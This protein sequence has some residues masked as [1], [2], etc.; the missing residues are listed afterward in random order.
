MPTI[1]QLPTATAPGPQDEIPLSQ[2]GITRAVTVADLLSGT[3]QAIE[4]ASPSVLGRASL[5]PGGPEALSLGLGLAVQNA[6][7]LANGNDHAAFVQETTFGAGDEAIINA[8]GIP[9][10]LPLPGL[11][12]LFSGGSNVSIDTNGVIASTTDPSVS[13]SLSTLTQS[14]STTQASLATLAS[15]IPTGGIAGLNGAGQVTAPIAGDVSLGKVLVSTGATSR[16]VAQRAGDTINVLDFGAVRGGPDCTAAFNAAIAALPSSGAELFIP[17][18]EYWFSSGVVVNGKAFAMKGAGRGQTRLH[19]QH[20]GI[21]FDISPGDIL[22]KVTLAGF[23]LYA[24]SSAGQTAAGI[25][26]TY[27]ATSSFGYVSASITEIEF[28]G[29]PNGANGLAPFP[30]TFLRGLVL[31]GCWSTEINSISW[32]GPPAAA[33]VTQSAV[34][35]L[36]QSFD[37]RMHGIQAYYGNALI[38]QTGYCEGIYL[39]APVVV[40]VD[41]LML[42]TDQTKWAGYAP[43]KTMLLGLWISH[44]EVNTNL[45]TVLL[46]NVTAGFLAGLDITRDGGPNTPQVLFN[47]TNVSNFHV[48]GCNFV[49][50]PTGGNSA[51]VAFSFSSTSDSSNNI[52]DGCHFED[53]ATVIQINGSNGTVGLT[54][55]GLNL[56]NVP[57][58]SAIIDHSD[59]TSG[60]YLSF[61]TPSQPGAPAGWGNSKDHVFSNPGGSILFRISNIQNAANFIRHQAATSSNPPTVCFDG[62][63]GTV[64]GVIQTKGGNLFINAAGGT[65]GSGNIVSLMNTQ[66]ATNWP[67]LQNATTGNLSL[68]STNTGGLGLQPKGALWLSPATGLFA[69]GLPTVK[70]ASGSNQIWNNNGV[71]SIA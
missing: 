13:G 37:T 54:T 3:Q 23:S 56:G 34:I 17:A 32:F 6:S 12:A 21:G 25:R 9:K 4:I 30:Q 52:I 11:R 47:L 49:G 58:A 43:G 1:V 16:S 35:E 38:L 51:D 55:Y 59:A 70:P 5:G 18:G 65:S 67:T 10:R 31:M 26:I 15:R 66:G 29:Y 28:F 42:Q 53:M 14:V 60:N 46:A 24:E 22:S 48:S 20:G 7:L 44:G 36:N 61:V 41:Y 57:L 69:P 8:G 45:G 50:G 39:G 2:A 33:G 19:L 68:I 71:L 40:G 27:P 64:N 62:A 63:D